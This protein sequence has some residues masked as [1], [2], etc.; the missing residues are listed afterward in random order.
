[1]SDNFIK[2][3]DLPKPDFNIS[4]S[5]YDRNNPKEYDQISWIINEVGYII[6][7]NKPDIVVVVGDTNSALASALAASKLGIPIAHIESGCRTYDKT[8]T[9]EIN[10]ILVDHMATINFAPTPN[11]ATNLIRECL[12]HDSKLYMVGHPIVDLLNEIKI[13]IHSSL[14]NRKYVFM[15]LH[16]RENITNED[17]LRG[18]MYDISKISKHIDVIFSCHPHT[19]VQ[20]K[21]FDI[22]L[23]KV[24]VINPVHYHDSLSLIKNAKFVI[25]DS[26]GI[27]QESAILGTPCISLI[28]ITGWVETV[29][30][31]MN[32]LVGHDTKKILD[33]TSFWTKAKSKPEFPPNIFG[34]IGVSKR[35]VDIL[36]TS[37]K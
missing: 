2:E 26:G 11:C 35:I 9:E 3:L 19:R 10:R 4:Q 29:Q 22:D 6:K 27:I 28:D 17:I 20:I 36:E 5:G 32:Q 25:T 21:K 37:S 33:T 18:I 12:Q 16:R 34:R 23:T 30:E 24:R 31:G 13:P 8:Q 14:L 15:T 7:T 1:M